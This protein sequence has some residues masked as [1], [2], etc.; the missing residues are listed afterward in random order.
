MASIL[1]YF[2]KQL[3]TTNLAIQGI[4]MP[5]LIKDLIIAILL[6]CLTLAI[7]TLG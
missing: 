5:I 2:L 6:V 7:T 3:P 4:T 1:P